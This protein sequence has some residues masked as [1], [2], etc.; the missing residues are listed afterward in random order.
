[1]MNPKNLNT[2]INKINKHDKGYEILSKHKRI[3]LDCYST[4]LNNNTLTIGGA[5][6]GKTEQYTVPNIIKAFGSYVI[7][8]PK[9]TLHKRLGR[10]LAKKGY[11]VIF[12]D[13]KHP[14]KSS[15]FNCFDFIKSEQDILELTEMLIN[16]KHD[17]NRYSQDPYWI[18]NASLVIEFAIA[19]MYDLIDPVDRNLSTMLK[20]IDDLQ[21]KV[22]VSEDEAS[23]RQDTYIDD[24]MEMLSNTKPGSLSVRLYNKF[25]YIPYKT[26]STILS[27]VNSIVGGY[28]TDSIMKMTKYNDVD[29]ASIGQEKTA[30]FVSVSDR[31]RS[32]DG[33]VNI[34]FSIAMKEL[35]DYA[36]DYCDDN[37]NRLPVEVR[38]F[39]DDFG[40]NV[41]ISNFPKII[42]SVRSRGI[43][44]SIMLQSEKQLESAFGED[45]ETIKSNCDRYIYMGTNDLATRERV[46]KAA[47]L[48]LSQVIELDRNKCIVMIAGQKA[49]IDDKVG[50][51]E[52]QPEVD[53]ELK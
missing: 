43:G 46:A 35:C 49:F 7:S 16:S 42:S 26:L 45:A 23:T 24:A 1:M 20:V 40:T 52:Y 33:L 30:V 37:N 21:E 27:Q 10:Y 34:F 51:N 32:L 17:S 15:H 28:H 12:I 44:I 48:P 53:R 3:S 13:F 4:H 8:D 36:D 11:K 50:I 47:N 25:R 14:E 29:L 2:K 6:T 41:T 38:F 18:D 5:G 19:Y 31:D 39:M 9:G 22:C